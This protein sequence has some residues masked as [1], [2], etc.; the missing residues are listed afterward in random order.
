MTISIAWAARKP[1]PTP[2]WMGFIRDVRD[3]VAMAP[4]AGAEG[5]G[6]AITNE[7]FVAFNRNGGEAVESFRMRR[8][9]S[10]IA[11]VPAG[12]RATLA[13][14]TILLFRE[15]GGEDVGVAGH[16]K[17]AEW[18]EARK[19]IQKTLGRDLLHETDPQPRAGFAGGILASPV[20]AGLDSA[21]DAFVAN[22][23]DDFKSI[24]LELSRRAREA[25]A[26]AD[27]M[28]GGLLPVLRDAEGVAAFTQ[29]Y[30][31]NA[32]AA[33]RD[34]TRV[35]LLGGVSARRFSTAGT[36]EAHNQLGAALLS[37]VLAGKSAVDVLTIASLEFNHLADALESLASAEASAGLRGLAAEAAELASRQ[38]RDE[39]EAAAISQVA[40]LV[41]HLAG[42]A[43]RLA[44]EA[45]PL[46]GEILSG[47]VSRLNGGL[48]ALLQDVGDGQVQSNKLLEAIRAASQHIRQS[49]DAGEGHSALVRAQN[50]WVDQPEYPLIDGGARLSQAVQAAGL[51]QG[52]GSAAGFAFEREAISSL[53][54]R[55]LEVFS[56]AA[57]NLL[58]G[59]LGQCLDL[60]G[61]Q[62]PAHQVEMV[63]SRLGSVVL[64]HDG[65]CVAA[66]RQMAAAV[67]DADHA[68]GYLHLSDGSRPLLDTLVHAGASLQQGD[69]E[70]ALTALSAAAQGTGIDPMDI[71]SLVARGLALTGDPQLAALHAYERLDAGS[72]MEISAN[73]PAELA[74]IDL[75]QVWSGLDATLSGVTSA[76][77][78]DASSAS[79]ADL[80]GQIRF[81]ADAR[82]LVE[83]TK[84]LGEPRRQIADGDRLERIEE[85]S[86][87]FDPNF[88][89]AP[90][91]LRAVI[92][93]D[94]L[95]VGGF[96]T[97]AK[98]E[99]TGLQL[100]S[101][102]GSWTYEISRGGGNGDLEVAVRFTSGDRIKLARAIGDRDALSTIRWQEG[103]LAQAREQIGL[104]SALPD[105]VVERLVA[106]AQEP[107][108]LRFKA[109]ALGNMEA[110]VSPGAD[111]GAAKKA[112]VKSI[113]AMINPAI[114]LQ[115]EDRLT[116][117]EGQE[118]GLAASGAGQG[119][120][121]VSG[122]YDQKGHSAAVSLGKGDVLN[123]TC[124]ETWHSL[125]HLFSLEEREILATAFPGTSGLDPKQNRAMFIEEGLS[126]EVSPTEHAAYAFGAWA[127]ARLKGFG[128]EVTHEGLQRRTLPLFQRMM[129]AQDRIA[130][131]GARNGFASLDAALNGLY[132]KVEGLFNTAL[133]GQ[134]GERAFGVAAHQA[135]AMVQFNPAVAMERF[136]GGL[137]QL[138][139]VVN[140]ED[141]STASPSVQ[142][143]ELSG[144]ATGLSMSTGLAQRL[145]AFCKHQQRKP[146]GVLIEAMRR[147]GLISPERIKSMSIGIDFGFMPTGSKLQYSLA[148]MSPDLLVRTSEALSRVS[149]GE[150]LSRADLGTMIEAA[151]ISRSG[152]GQA[153]FDALVG[154]A[155]TNFRFGDKAEAR[156]AAAVIAGALQALPDNI[157]GQYVELLGEPGPLSAAG[158]SRAQELVAEIGLHFG[159]STP[160]NETREISSASPLY[161]LRG[162]D[163]GRS[164][165]R[166]DLAFA[167]LEQAS[168]AMNMM[169][170]SMQAE[171]QEVSLPKEDAKAAIEEGLAN[172]EWLSRV[173][174]RSMP[175]LGGQLA[176]TSPLMAKAAATLSDEDAAEE[177]RRRH[178]L[179]TKCVDIVRRINPSMGVQF[180]EEVI[181]TDSQ[182]LA[183]SGAGGPGSPAAGF[184]NAAYNIA[185]ISMS[186]EVDPY[187]ASLHESWHSL[188][189]FLS[190]DERRV[191]AERFPDTSARLDL[192]PH[193]RR[194]HHENVAYAFA[195]WAQARLKLES[196]EGLT[197]KDRRSLNLGAE[198]SIFSGFRDTMFRLGSF[199]SGS[200]WRAPKDVFQEAIDGYIGLRTRPFGQAFPSLSRMMHGLDRGLEKLTTSPMK[201]IQV[202]QKRVPAGIALGVGTAAIGAAVANAKGV[203]ALG[204]EAGDISRG[205]EALTK[206]MAGENGY[207]AL[208]RAYE[209][210]RTAIDE[211]AQSGIDLFSQVMVS[212]LGQK[213]L[214]LGQ[215]VAS[216]QFSAGEGGLSEGIAS[217]AIR[218]ASAILDGQQLGGKAAAF[219][220]HGSSDALQPD[221]VIGTIVFHPIENGVKNT[222]SVYPIWIQLRNNGE[223]S[224]RRI[225]YSSAGR[226]LSA[227]HRDDF[228]DAHVGFA[229]LPAAIRY[230]AKRLQDA[231]PRP[232]KELL[233]D[234][235][236]LGSVRDG[237]RYSASSNPIMAGTSI[238]VPD[239]AGNRL[240]LG[241]VIG[242]DLGLKP[243]F[244]EL[245][246]RPSIKDGREI[247]TWDGLEP[248]LYMLRDN[249]RI[250]HAFVGLTGGESSFIPLHEF[251]ARLLGSKDGR[252]EVSDR[253]LALTLDDYA[254]A[255]LAGGRNLTAAGEEVRKALDAGGRFD[256]L[257]L[258][259]SGALD[260][261]ASAL[262]A[263]ERI[264][265]IGILARNAEVAMAAAGAG[266]E[267]TLETVI[268][269]SEK[270][271][272]AGHRYSLGTGVPAGLEL[273]SLTTPAYRSA[274]DD[275]LTAGQVPVRLI[276]AD[277]LQNAAI[278]R[279]QL[280]GRAGEIGIVRPIIRVKEGF[281]QSH[282][283]YD[284]VHIPTGLLFAEVKQNREI[285]SMDKA[286]AGRAAARLAV[287]LSNHDLDRNLTAATVSL[288]AGFKP[289]FSLSEKKDIPPELIAGVA[290]DLCFADAPVHD[291]LMEQ[292]LLSSM[293]QMVASMSS[294]VNARLKGSG[295]GLHAA[296]KSI[297]VL[298]ES[299]G[300]HP[301]HVLYARAP[302]MVYN[303][304]GGIGAM[305]MPEAWTHAGAY[306]DRI[307]MITEEHAAGVVGRH[308]SVG[309][310]AHANTNV[311][312]PATEEQVAGFRVG[313]WALDRARA[314][315]APEAAEAMERR[316]E[317]A[318]L[319][320]HPI[321]GKAKDSEIHDASTSVGAMFERMGGHLRAAVMHAA[322][323]AERAEAIAAALGRNEARG[324]EILNIKELRAIYPAE[325]N[326]ELAQL[327]VSDLRRWA[328]AAAKGLDERNAAKARAEA[329]RAEREETRDNPGKQHLQNLA[330]AYTRGQSMNFGSFGDPEDPADP[331][332]F[333][334]RFSVA[335]TGLGVTNEELLISAAF[336]P[337]I[338]S[339]Q[340]GRIMLEE[341]YGL[342]SIRYCI[343][344]IVTAPA[345]T[346][347]MDIPL[348]LQDAA[349]AGRI[350]QVQQERQTRTNGGAAAEEI[351]AGFFNAYQAG[352][353]NVVSPDLYRWAHVQA[354]AT[355]MQAGQPQLVREQAESAAWRRFE[356]QG[357]R[358]VEN[359]EILNPGIRPG[360]HEEFQIQ[361]GRLRLAALEWQRR[362][363][364]GQGSAASSV[365]D[366]VFRAPANVH[367]KPVVSVE[368]LGQPLIGLST[369]TDQRRYSLADT[370][371]PEK[372]ARVPGSTA[373][374]GISSGRP[375]S[376]LTSAG[377]AAQIS[378]A[379]RYSV[380][381]NEVYDPGYM[382]AVRHVA[383]SYSQDFVALGYALTSVNTL[384]Q[385]GRPAV[386]PGFV[387][388]EGSDRL[389]IVP[390]L[391][392][393]GSGNDGTVV[394]DWMYVST[395]EGFCFNSIKFRTPEFAAA[396]HQVLTT[397]LA[398]VEG[399]MTPE[400]FRNGGRVVN[401]IMADAKALERMMK[402]EANVAIAREAE[403]FKEK[404]VSRGKA[405]AEAAVAGAIEKMSLIGWRPV[406]AAINLDEGYYGGLSSIPA[407]EPDAH[408]KSNLIVAPNPSAYSSILGDE[409]TWLM[410]NRHSGRTVGEPVQFQTPETAAMAAASFEE[411][412]PWPLLQPGYR[413]NPSLA[414]FVSSREEG[415]VSALGHWQLQDA[416]LANTRLAE[417]S[418][419]PS[420]ALAVARRTAADI[421]TAMPKDEGAR[422]LAEGMGLAANLYE[423]VEKIAGTASGPA[424]S[425]VA[426]RVLTEMDGKNI[427]AAD[428]NDVRQVIDNLLEQGGY[429]PAHKDRLS[430]ALEPA[431]AAIAGIPVLVEALH[432][433]AQ[434]DIEAVNRENLARRALVLSGT[435]KLALLTEEDIDFQNYGSELAQARTGMMREAAYEAGAAEG[436]SELY[437]T[438]VQ[439]AKRGNYL[440]AMRYFALHRQQIL[441]EGAVRAQQSGV[442]IDPQIVARMDAYSAGLQSDNQRLKN[443]LSE[444]HSVQAELQ[445]L[446]GMA[447]VLSP[448]ER[449]RRYANLYARLEAATGP[450]KEP[451][452]AAAATGRRFSIAG[453]MKDVEGVTAIGRQNDTAAA[454]AERLRELGFTPSSVAPP[455]REAGSGDLIIFGI[456][457]DNGLALMPIVSEKPGWAI[458]HTGSNKMFGHVFHDVAIATEAFSR[459]AEIR[460]WNEP[461]PASRHAQNRL[462]QD[463]NAA[464]R[465]AASRD[466]SLYNERLMAGY[467]PIAAAANGYDVSTPWWI[468]VAESGNPYVDPR[469]PFYLLYP[470]RDA[471]LEA[472][473][474]EVA[475]V[476][477][478]QSS[479]LDLIE[480][481]P[482]LDT[483]LRG[484]YESNANIL[485]E[486]V[487]EY[488]SA[489]WMRERL[490]GFASDQHMS[491]DAAG[492]A[493]AAHYDADAFIADI[494]SGNWIRPGGERTAGALRDTV[495]GSAREML[496]VER[497]RY[498]DTMG[499]ERLATYGALSLM[500]APDRLASTMDI[501][502]AEAADRIAR[503]QAFAARHQ[504]EW[505]QRQ[506][507]ELIRQE[508]AFDPLKLAEAGFDMSRI[509]WFPAESGEVPVVEALK[510]GDLIGFASRAEATDAFPDRS[511]VPVYVRPGRSLDLTARPL[512][513]SAVKFLAGWHAEV[514]EG[515]RPVG[516]AE[517]PEGFLAAVASGN[518]KAFGERS[519]DYKRALAARA[520]LVSYDS[521]RMPNPAGGGDV[522]IATDNSNMRL[523]FD[524]W[525]SREGERV[526]EEASP[527]V[528][529]AMRP[530]TMFLDAAAEQQLLGSRA[531]QGGLVLLDE[532]GVDLSA[533]YAAIPGAAAAHDQAILRQ[534]GIR[535]IVSA[536]LK[537][538]GHRGPM[539]MLIRDRD[540]WRSLDDDARI[541][542]QAAPG[543]M[544][545]R[546]VE[547]EHMAE[548]AVED[549]AMQRLIREATAG[550]AMLAMVRIDADAAT[551]SV[552]VVAAGT[553]GPE[554]IL[555]EHI[556]FD[557][558]LA[559][560][561]KSVNSAI[562]SAQESVSHRR[563][564]EIF[565]D[566][567]IAARS[568]ETVAIQS[569]GSFVLFGA[570][571][572]QIAESI[573]ALKSRLEVPPLGSDELPMLRLNQAEVTAAAAHLGSQGKRMMIASDHRRANWR[574]IEQLASQPDISSFIGGM[575]V[576]GAGQ[577]GGS[578]SIQQDPQQN[579][580]GQQGLPQQIPLQA[581]LQQ[582]LAMKPPAASPQ[583][584]QN[585][586]QEAYSTHR[587][588]VTLA[589]ARGEVLPEQVLRDYRP[590]MV[591]LPALDAGQARRFGY[592][593]EKP[594]YR[595]VRADEPLW[596]AADGQASR[597]WLDP[598]HVPNG[599][600]VKVQAFVV[601]QAKV[602]DLSSGGPS[603]AEMVQAASEIVVA[604]QAA[605]PEAA[606]LNIPGLVGS[607]Q[608][609]RVRAAYGDLL[610]QAGMAQEQVA[611]QVDQLE[612][613]IAN[614]AK[615]RG[616]AAVSLTDE[617][618]RPYLVI[619]DS[620]LLMPWA[621]IRGVDGQSQPGREQRQESIQPQ[622]LAPDVTATGG[623]VRGASEIL[624]PGVFA[625]DPL[626]AGGPSQAAAPLRTAEPLIG[627]T[628]APGRQDLPQAPAQP[629]RNL[630][631]ENPISPLN[632]PAG[633]PA[634]N[635]NFALQNAGQG[636]PNTMPIMDFELDEQQQNTRAAIEKAMKLIEE[637]PRMNNGLP[638][639]EEVVKIL[640]SIEVEGPDGGKQQLLNNMLLKK[641]QPVAENVYPLAPG[642][643]LFYDNKDKRFLCETVDAFIREVGP[644]GKLARQFSNAQS[645]IV[646]T[647]ADWS[648]IGFDMGDPETQQAINVFQRDVSSII[649]Q[650]APHAE[651]V[652]MPKLFGSGASVRNSGAALGD[653][654]PV[655]GLAYRNFNLFLVSA[656]PSRG[657][658]LETAYHE[659]Y[660]L[661]S[662]MLTN[663]E[664]TELENSAELIHQ[665][666][667]AYERE[668]SEKELLKLRAD[669]DQLRRKDPFSVK[670]RGME[671][672]MR[673]LEE[674]GR[675]NQP[676]HSSSGGVPT[677]EERSAEAFA[678]LAAATRRDPNFKIGRYSP[679][680]MPK[681]NT[682][683][684]KIRDKVQA[685]RDAAQRTKETARDAYNE[686][687]QGVLGVM[688][689][690]WKLTWSAIKIGDKA[691]EAAPGK[692][693][694]EIVDQLLKG[695]IAKRVQ[696]F[697]MS[698]TM[699]A[700]EAQRILRLA[701][702]D[703]MAVTLESF[704][705]SGKA[706]SNER[707]Y[708]MMATA[709]S[710][711]QCRE[712]LV[713]AGYHSIEDRNG[714]TD[715]HADWNEMKSQIMQ[716]ASSPTPDRIGEPAPRAAAPRSS[717]AQLEPTE[718]P[719]YQKQESFVQKEMSAPA[720][721]QQIAVSRRV[722]QVASAMGLP[723]RS[724]EVEYYVYPAQPA[725]GL[726]PIE[727]PVANY[728]GKGGPQQFLA[729][730]HATL[731]KAAI[732]TGRMVMPAALE[733]YRDQPWASSYL[734]P[735]LDQA[736]GDN[737]KAQ[738]RGP[739]IAGTVAA[740]V[741]G[742]R[743]SAAQGR[744][745]AVE[746]TADREQAVGPGA[747]YRLFQDNANPELRWPVYALTAGA[748][749][750]G[751]AMP[752]ADM[753][754][755]A[756][757]ARALVHSH[758]EGRASLMPLAFDEVQADGSRLLRS[759]YI[760]MGGQ[761]GD[762][763]IGAGKREESGWGFFSDS[764]PPASHKLALHVPGREPVEIAG[765]GSELQALVALRAADLAVKAHREGY[766][767]VADVTFEVK[768]IG[769]EGFALYAS[770]GGNHATIGVFRD[771]VAAGKARD[772]FLDKV[773]K[774]ASVA[775]EQQRPDMSVSDIAGG[776]LAGIRYSIA[777]GDNTD[778]KPLSATVETEPS[779]RGF[780]KDDAVRAGG[781]ALVSIGVATAATQF[782]DGLSSA[783]DG[784]L[785]VLSSVE[786]AVGA[787]IGASREVELR[788]IFREG[789]FDALAGSGDR[790][791]AGARVDQAIFEAGQA[792]RDL[793]EKAA[794]TVDGA[795]RG[796]E[797]RTGLDLGA[798]ASDKIFRE[799]NFDAIAGS[800]QTLSAEMRIRAAMEE[801]AEALQNIAS[802]AKE[803]LREAGL[804]AERQTGLDLG[805]AS[806]DPVFSNGNFDAIAG[807]GEQ[808]ELA[809]R[810]NQ[811]LFDA[812]MNVEAAADGVAESTTLAAAEVNRVM[813]DAVGTDVPGLVRDMDQA[814][815][816]AAAQGE[817]AAAPLL[818]R[819]RDGVDALGGAF[820]RG[821][822]VFRDTLGGGSEPAVM[823]GYDAAQAASLSMQDLPE[824]V[825]LSAVEMANRLAT[826]VGDLANRAPDRVLGTAAEIAGWAQAVSIDA[827]VKASD[828]L[829]RTVGIP[830]E[831]LL[832][833]LGDTIGNVRFS[834]AGARLDQAGLKEPRIDMAALRRG[835]GAVS[836][837]ARTQ[838]DN[839]EAIMAQPAQQ[840]RIEVTRMEGQLAQGQQAVSRLGGFS[841]IA[842]QQERNRQAAEA[843][844][845]N[846]RLYLDVPENDRARAWS[847][848][849][850]VDARNG[851]MFIDKDGEKAPA[852]ASS[853]KAAAQPAEKWTRDAAL[854]Q[855]DKRSQEIAAAD[856]G[857]AMAT[858]VFAV[859]SGRSGGIRPE[860]EDKR[861]GRSGRDNVGPNAHNVLEA[862]EQLLASPV[863]QIAATGRSM[864]TEAGEARNRTAFAGIMPTAGNTGPARGP[865]GGLGAGPQASRMKAAD[866]PAVR[867]QKPG[868]GKAGDNQAGGGNRQ[869]TIQAVSAAPLKPSITA[870]SV[871]DPTEPGQ[872]DSLLKEMRGMDSKLF[873][874]RLK[875]TQSAYADAVARITPG[876]AQAS[877]FVARDRL[878][879]GLSLGIAAAKERGLQVPAF[880]RQKP[881]AETT[882]PSPARRRDAGNER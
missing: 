616:Y 813:R 803:V 314:Q 560:A 849:A 92:G 9:G 643:V 350:R 6:N 805:V 707:L 747:V 877:M 408:K 872:R 372:P 369:E 610:R 98:A 754:L 364:A 411:L 777:A 168:A 97:R 740:R 555:Q 42:R 634:A 45:G 176:E 417:M 447:N 497:I 640:T 403:R 76:L 856:V 541:L 463:A 51:A 61:N 487:A 271:E 254:Q 142:S 525:R 824:R 297:P 431:P 584:Q 597:M 126:G 816:K 830:A 568:N 215:A 305:A 402:E 171:I 729:Q 418:P 591:G 278:A 596:P 488:A 594:Y 876:A 434:D 721:K 53:S 436:V 173:E 572:A 501:A 558:A 146:E 833:R 609:G 367:L 111:Q 837:A 328:Q 818:E 232:L 772:A 576:G 751:N 556:S 384:G 760:A 457:P 105:P 788:K 237:K 539:A 690:A 779:I 860:D 676:Y 224:V 315:Y 311:T 387:L 579:P 66:A 179:V 336:S 366:N 193:L 455:G 798:T 471:A 332:S 697:E 69:G 14:A 499:I 413:A 614:G 508:A 763:L 797:G 286:Q 419:R 578:M 231:S 199:L 834:A 810:I 569:Q 510:T 294:N 207:A 557:Q 177:E 56:S 167:S 439:H 804:A 250:R 706:V 31:N 160:M 16:A 141:V 47:A 25:R 727:A 800:G 288:D 181:G 143:V 783:G 149:S 562:S 429:G 246:G 234:G 586:L 427:F 811:A 13:L 538:S 796:I 715:I 655:A 373:E 504:A 64:A 469:A 379:R 343:A 401:A 566:T 461:L 656:D 829:E 448:A 68:R 378:G 139:I 325:V 628:A 119:I 21:A 812:R 370:R 529:A 200:G 473:A 225:S 11:H 108:S 466:A 662:P 581:Y 470:T 785:G 441:G 299:A 163:Q 478:R 769:D 212:E 409:P 313:R 765:F 749:T 646:D 432:A 851:Q 40:P 684:G 592:D 787:D 820:K 705:K 430:S 94:S 735:V 564:R 595:A 166:V 134:V 236:D 711:M 329:S 685:L 782:K 272:L 637:S 635:S 734:P 228:G 653:R 453:N 410:I 618:G 827:A 874:E 290:K 148:G 8:R 357:F 185:T 304:S 122:W 443:Q 306:A 435:D 698:D 666:I 394:C 27:R 352:D 438:G 622:S 570:D 274:V 859:A 776:K 815:V 300:Y 241:A 301:D 794:N 702:L 722:E 377:L 825:E 178:E 407:F 392:I 32:T 828:A 757:S 289:R 192:P 831:D 465:P 345:S 880:V 795:L 285:Q 412:L 613:L 107:G 132:G 308:A 645:R 12:S 284:Y 116:P 647:M 57:Q 213:A 695:E 573:P 571:A 664:K 479:Q 255:A 321:F 415:F 331:P 875:A 850:R 476:Y 307:R 386:F 154:R 843:L 871:T 523:A 683:F 327:Q 242:T 710:P 291:Y 677:R 868:T 679:G 775:N 848:G 474:F 136:A 349:I 545:G 371:M 368:Y 220:Y 117:S 456:S 806:S 554:T 755:D 516:L 83:A 527:A 686:A 567:M 838:A 121:E 835:L 627:P 293:P 240:W 530:R 817:A 619:N 218:T 318:E 654:Q 222:D 786:Q 202:L 865:S 623:T 481:S 778:G 186:P 10:G 748:L 855:I 28:Q 535:S 658:V 406:E 80:A 631:G 520:Q 3:M 606:R 175:A 780:L 553:A 691:E 489:L 583:Q 382:E 728:Q 214:E 164:D 196:G 845:G 858:G 335:G 376:S 420:E 55:S 546:L 642:Y 605:L 807:S 633:M 34:A 339:A 533:S 853:F 283:G 188:E 580:S 359:R 44:D 273:G 22:R 867:Q 381:S 414:A 269:L 770:A 452:I 256:A 866:L 29:H 512:S 694:V 854:S 361:G 692:R 819:V 125:E 89:T 822:E 629:M 681:K 665:A 26:W 670:L 505:L 282:R 773:H 673:I 814:L 494:R 496:G 317:S 781:L 400:D 257:R 103:R 129:A 49:I 296:M 302:V 5:A 130:A 323:E 70:S 863:K 531:A 708:K 657:D 358:R 131:W 35:A 536:S 421:A 279:V 59:D 100:S 649:A 598:S 709:H 668:Q 393:E 621:A 543:M 360:L 85:F 493:A 500:L 416:A 263:E 745:S 699:P 183:A 165:N 84:T 99:A 342:E 767:L 636:G 458:L 330:R 445:Q 590:D 37:H 265:A 483:L 211:A 337:E 604:A 720:G 245:V 264:A 599:P 731:I 672:R 513:E 182:A 106:P 172:G 700:I 724:A 844:A 4:L 517:N 687:G 109:A 201:W 718:F 764:F 137:Q 839:L 18:L 341:G 365:A 355:W 309:E 737:G 799:G 793:T 110:F 62:L 399:L 688:N 717:K 784:V 603:Q 846:S 312:I 72:R 659:A 235:F 353:A 7:E 808:V 230:A 547:I 611:A 195:D 678:R 174:G 140:P 451:P 485:Q 440:E 549:T 617:L 267:P 542:A 669:S 528:L 526:L 548:L 20:P 292:N 882:R 93:S 742:I 725:L 832:Q 244:E 275:A 585:L 550:G 184:F 50:L 86:V 41:R 689:A 428:F 229:D 515:L 247:V 460:D 1:L 391:R 270:L 268:R 423:A 454:A 395:N 738:R 123:N 157:R 383:D 219:F 648:G 147:G 680:L 356:L 204:L 210:G 650:I 65:D 842:A 19:L 486:N 346:G 17:P 405:Y 766:P 632:A 60:L 878:K 251:Y 869:Y 771:G 347:A 667:D 216:F 663:E 2:V 36:G 480:L 58:R 620:S 467:D 389:A 559:A 701:G 511:A 351:A 145:D 790:L 608:G 675:S 503:E 63:A 112:M 348:W 433:A 303:G 801:G 253:R 652:V 259:V 759:G 593:L 743:Y 340:L 588:F 363:E 158:A 397:A 133:E 582:F 490:E 641:L 507:V 744:P 316:K 120:A 644:R 506:R 537:E 189:S 161:V 477:V 519:E 233:P 524:R 227:S 344:P 639:P 660:H 151:E 239:N 450:E 492:A 809:G 491:A 310:I 821:Y 48:Q 602:L 522:I 791:A 197:P 194:S 191:L 333:S 298:L 601:K 380:G 426:R 206:E 127:E 280:L 135:H 532:L 600:G 138:G 153:A 712:F 169:P 124:H 374:A 696:R 626:R 847:M 714:R 88:P 334:R 404:V 852:L 203:E 472:N 534:N 73:I 841:D 630:Q 864:V 774:A 726:G 552:E 252:I 95:D 23:A 276:G 91:R 324:E 33:E 248:G 870:F 574:G 75:A 792:W 459:V 589:L 873:I 565:L 398:P 577:L 52:N 521:I 840:Q 249:G 205:L 723:P 238:S 424:G 102:P 101:T 857:G 518:F 208:S 82:L 375:Y 761:S 704:A 446:N 54:D 551:A 823:P 115:V 113:A 90:A 362:I 223:M 295:P 733:P 261:E 155:Q 624:K 671:D 802:Q 425:Q 484:F 625:I 762:W 396:G 719:W 354:E 67:N 388:R 449:D 881:A 746:W 444:L 607:L 38:N 96:P 437:E 385:D 104:A 716:E 468:R 756:A 262:T 156:Q 30:E 498:L 682:F 81:S 187:N 281:D 836:N 514:R 152:M 861:Q 674:Q 128:P 879:A 277:G 789:D 544:A 209:A 713:Q 226:L 693:A 180:A 482:Q 739:A 114:E 732:D 741:S 495:F 266:K 287:A 612:R 118:T 651:G 322:R 162:V 338:P 703:R 221:A 638:R 320:N 575:A 79:L 74:D 758:A 159:P 587:T 462:I 170:Q 217:R 615:M 736:I 71:G 730:V 15:H 39:D 390:V 540:A 753:A 862:V 422:V 563:L 826:L 752:L 46:G 198:E 509:V 326:L 502:A 190:Q 77:G 87:S 78:V 561:A 768:S 661:L 464:M 475:P 150:R 442:G 144:I 24:G 43:V 258:S 750:E 319:D 260:A 243:H